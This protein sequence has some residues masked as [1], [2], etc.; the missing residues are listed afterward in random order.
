LEDGRVSPRGRSGGGIGVFDEL[1][2]GFFLVDMVI[3]VVVM[4]F[5]L[6]VG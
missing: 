3:M 5:L 1:G 2:R 4:T 6:V